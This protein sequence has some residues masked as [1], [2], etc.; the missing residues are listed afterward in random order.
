MCVCRKRIPMCV[1]I[2]IYVY[3]Y[4]HMELQLIRPSVSNKGEGFSP[5]PKCGAV[6]AGFY[7]S[8]CSRGPR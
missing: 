3:M 6:N 8:G 4:V 2:Y 5:F 7:S 1:S